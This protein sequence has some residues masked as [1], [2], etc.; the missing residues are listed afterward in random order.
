M[1]LLIDAH[2][3]IAWNVLTFGRDYTQSALWNRTR[4]AESSIE[5]FIGNTLLGKSEWLLGHTGIIFSTLFCAPERHSLGSWDT[6]NYRTSREA[7]RRAMA[8]LDVYKKLIDSDNQFV[9]ISSKADLSGV[10]ASWRAE[11]PIADR[12]IGFVPL[13]EGADPIVEPQQVEEWY[14][15]GLRI[16]GLSWES[17]VYAGGTHEPGPVTAA[18]FELLEVMSDLN[19]ILDL[20]HLSEEAYYQALEAYDGPMIA[21]HANPRRFCPTSRGLSEDMI[22]NLAELDGVIG[23]VP[24][25]AFLKPGWRRHHP[26]NEVSLDLVADAIDHICQL[27]GNSCHV[28]FGS[29]FDGGFGLE[30]VPVGIDSIAD[31]HKVAD[32][33][34]GRG[35]TEEQIDHV[36]SE[37][38]LRM[39][40]R[41]LPD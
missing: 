8:Q 22:I 2:E 19:M 5:Q 35:Y 28:A 29:D 6:Q 41:S 4:E 7:H 10:L 9:L 21:S 33:L 31:L 26:R 12:R 37:N 34:A 1:R 36:F 18:G 17:T 11:L 30:H 20:S 16:I 32:L 15:R 24:Y 25:N 3:D 23:I 27:T 40:R 13:M 39:L 14:G 38:W